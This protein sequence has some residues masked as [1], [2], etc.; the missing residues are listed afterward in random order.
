MM[1]VMTKLILNLALLRRLVLALMLGAVAAPFAA[2]G[3]THA[4]DNDGSAGMGEGLGLIEEGARLLLRG[5]VDEMAPLL[6]DLEGMI[7]DLALYHPPEILPNG[8]ILLRRRVPRD[9]EVAP[10]DGIEGDLESGEEID[11]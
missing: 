4:D 1:R 10:D 9:P 7:D 3:P 11:I 2:V 5:F 6:R 8:D